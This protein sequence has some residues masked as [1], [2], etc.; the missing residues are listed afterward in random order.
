MNIQGAVKQVIVRR[1]RDSVALHVTAFN[2]C[3]E[4]VHKQAIYVPKTMIRLLAETLLK[5]R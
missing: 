5:F 4:E 2:A 1:F 3:G